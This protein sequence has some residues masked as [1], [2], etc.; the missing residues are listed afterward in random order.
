MTPAVFPA[1][2][3][4]GQT[5]SVAN[6]DGSAYEVV[7]VS[8]VSGSSFTATFVSAK[9]GPGITLQLVNAYDT[10]YGS[11]EIANCHFEN[12]DIAGIQIGT[13]PAVA[14]ATP[15][16]YSTFTGSYSAGAQTVTPSSMPPGIGA[17][18]HLFVSSADGSNG[19]VVV[20]VS[21]SETTFTTNF[22]KVKV[23]G[24][25]QKFF[26]DYGCGPLTISNCQFY[27]G[28][29]GHAIDNAGSNVAIRQCGA[30]GSLAGT[31][32]I[33]L[34]PSAEDSRVQDNPFLRLGTAILDQGSIRPIIQ[35]NID[36]D[37]A[38]GA[39]VLPDRAVPFT[40]PIEIV[41]QAV[42]GGDLIALIP[43]PTVN[44]NSGI[45][46]QA[47]GGGPRSGTVATD[48]S[49]TVTYVSGDVF[50]SEYVGMTIMIG[51]TRYVVASVV[52]QISLTLT[53]SAPSSSGQS[54]SVLTFGNAYLRMGNGT[55]APVIAGDSSSSIIKIA[56]D[57]SCSNL[58]AKF[59]SGFNRLLQNSEVHGILSL[60]NMDGGTDILQ[61]NRDSNGTIADTTKHAFNVA[62]TGN[63]LVFGEYDSTGAIVGTNFTLK[64]GGLAL[65]NSPSG[66]YKADSNGLLS[67]VTI[68]QMQADLGVSTS[69][70]GSTSGALLAAS[71]LS[72]LANKATARSNLSAVT[73]ASIPTAPTSTIGPATG[74]YDSAVINAI[75]NRLGQLV[76]GYNQVAVAFNE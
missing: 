71:N 35:N 51:G 22:S 60:I 15:P 74:T 14:G 70:S 30:A 28:S 58:W 19:E 65:I 37:G 36:A 56:S 68:A 10:N 41:S 52:S 44:A 62:L 49:V 3:V 16:P 47:V 64:L 73:R 20:V 21:I 57:R 63:S 48:G 12:N 38:P 4:P 31:G 54:Y 39:V 5:F 13:K 25:I 18:R 8:S 29:G 9:T 1:G 11:L 27:E 45:T 61:F 40:Q 43:N 66:Y 26:S 53:V 76:A 17:G 59:E 50:I 69:G 24:I 33:I 2:C 32:D 6:S 55:G 42:G 67:P 23:G 34:R 7:Y 75:I 46:I 72:D